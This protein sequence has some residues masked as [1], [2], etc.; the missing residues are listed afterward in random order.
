MVFE[1]P[2]PRAVV[3]SGFLAKYRIAAK[4]KYPQGKPV[5]F[6][7]RSLVLRFVQVFWLHQIQSYSSKKLI[8]NDLASCFD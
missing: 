4:H 1:S 7:S 6:E 2:Q 3:R 8:Y 5:V